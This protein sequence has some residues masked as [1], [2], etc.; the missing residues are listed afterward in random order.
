[1][2]RRWTARRGRFAQWGRR[3]VSE[4][5]DPRRAPRRCPRSGGAAPRHRRILHR[6]G[7]RR[8]GDRGAGQLDVVRSWRRHVFERGEAG[9]AGRSGIAHRDA[10]SGERAGG[11]GDG[12]WCARGTR[13]PGRDRGQRHRGAVGRERGEA[14]RDG[15]PGVR[16]G[17]GGRL[18]PG[19]CTST[20]TAPGSG[21]K[22]Y[23]RR[24]PTSSRHL[25]RGEHRSGHGAGG[26]HRMRGSWA[27]RDGV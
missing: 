7:S 18:E 13:R 12:A 19:P 21:V 2:Q 6:R 20:A 11:R 1:M 23:A 14:G 10:R 3:P 22:R 17:P 4:G 16:R 26:A 24:S 15:M 25:N 5:R 9:D 27:A 8:G